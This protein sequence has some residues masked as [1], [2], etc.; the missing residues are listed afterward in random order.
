MG[1]SAMAYSEEARAR[2]KDSMA[3]RFAA[4][5]DLKAS[6][7]TYV[8]IRTGIIAPEGTGPTGKAELTEDRMSLGAVTRTDLAEMTVACMGNDACANM[9]FAAEDNSLMLM[10]E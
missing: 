7:L 2:T 10:R 1:D 3:E 9:T 8:I 4:E 6:G 5:E